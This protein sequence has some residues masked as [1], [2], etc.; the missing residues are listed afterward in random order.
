MTEMTSDDRGRRIAADSAPPA[1]E[2]NHPQ[3]TYAYL[4]QSAFDGIVALDEEG[5]IT[6][7]NTAAERVLGYRRQDVI[8][9]HVTKI[10]RDL[11]AA[12]RINKLLFASPD[13]C[14]SSE[15]V[16][17]VSS[18]GEMIPVRISAS[19]LLDGEGRPIGSA[20][21]F[22]DVRQSQIIASRFGDLLDVVKE[23]AS[24][25]V[26]D[27]Q[28]RL[29][30]AAA[31]K[32][33]PAAVKGSFH[34]FDPAVNQLVPWVMDGYTDAVTDLARFKPGEGIAGLV[35]QTHKPIRV[36]DAEHDER[37]KPLPAPAFHSG[38][39]V[40]IPLLYSGVAL[41]TLSLDNPHKAEAFTEEDVRLLEK[42]A[43]IAAVMLENSWQH[44]RRMQDLQ[45][46]QTV[47][48]MLGDA[49]HLEATLNLVVD[50][51]R[52][53]TDSRRA[54]LYTL[55]RG[56]PGLLSL[57]VRASASRA[58]DDSTASDVLRAD[59][60]VAAHVLRTGKI[61]VERATDGSYR[62]IAPLPDAQLQVAGFLV[63]FTDK[64]EGYDDNARA[65]AVTL[66]HQ[67]ALALQDESR[68]I[69]LQEQNRKLEEAKQELETYGV[70]AAM[71][72]FGAEVT[73]S[74]GQKTFVL[75][76][77][78]ESIRE[79][80]PRN[81][82]VAG[83]VS[84]IQEE[85]QRI[86][87]FG[88]RIARPMNY[89]P[90]QSQL[91]VDASIR[92][93]VPDWC[94]RQS[95]VRLELA[96]GCEGARINVSEELLKGALHKLVENALRAVAKTGGGRLALKTLLQEGCVVMDLSDTGPGIPPHHLREFLRQKVTKTQGEPGLGMGV[97]MARV[98]FRY[99]GGDLELIETGPLGT[100]LRITLPL[101][102]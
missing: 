71:G 17:L 77:L 100:S 11:E 44:H 23:I 101:A 1:D 45:A 8:G 46:V 31:R 78:A 81:K 88:L 37:V 53:R 14:V 26:P 93:W 27:E 12:R 102:H 69:Q 79:M 18:A 94:Q 50:L 84:Q 28:A 73:H 95:N 89:P 38:S 63:L 34:R 86:S 83:I 70:V 33:I 58:A 56:G 75:V 6:E 65:L 10:Y 55:H 92:T 80:Y 30:L 22:Q 99:Y 40:S 24:L 87:N 39:L 15:H 4:L 51:I 41:G 97:F 5:Y 72:M 64:E 57:A 25:Q 82:K 96:L 54:D 68:I 7:F 90:A 35:Y 48:G 13:H 21:H 60:P 2:P 42:Y 43:A 9:Q 74:L 85:A 36:D 49:A 20:G 32:A 98:V 19:L 76:N 3:S 61:A 52:Q 66:A 47:E 91:D 62:L 29:I 16:E 59:D 67:A